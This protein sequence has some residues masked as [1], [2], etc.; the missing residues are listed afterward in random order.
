MASKESDNTDQ[1]VVYLRT[2]CSRERDF[3]GQEFSILAAYLSL[4]YCTDRRPRAAAT[5]SYLLQD[6]KVQVGLIYVPRAGADSG[7]LPRGAAVQV[8]GLDGKTN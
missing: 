2:T 3:A 4:C 6:R 7:F 1:E 8:T 5:L